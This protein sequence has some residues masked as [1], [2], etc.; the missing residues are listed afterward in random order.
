MSCP[1]PDER[2]IGLGDEIRD[3]AGNP[4]LEQEL[5]RLRV[6]HDVEQRLARETVRDQAKG[7][8]DIGCTLRR[9]PL[10]K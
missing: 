10:L 2:G 6:L 1:R 4:A 7:R 5:A 3:L 9:H 8:A